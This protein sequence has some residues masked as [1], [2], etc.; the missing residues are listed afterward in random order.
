MSGIFVDVSGVGRPPAGPS[1]SIQQ[2]LTANGGTSLTVVHLRESLQ[3]LI[4]FTETLSEY[5]PA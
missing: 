3:T 1:W 4:F 5:Y 2:A